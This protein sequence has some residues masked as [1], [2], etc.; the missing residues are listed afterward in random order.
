[1]TEPIKR[2]RTTAAAIISNP[3]MYED[4]L[5]RIDA[6]KAALQVMVYGAQ[7]R[8]TRDIESSQGWVS[9]ILTYPRGGTTRHGTVMPPQVSLSTLA[10]MEQWIAEHGEQWRKDKPKLRYNEPEHP[11]HV[12]AT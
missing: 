3:A 11:L 6:I 2:R 8:M 4:Y 10:A 7:A 9:A 5:R 12:D 1:M